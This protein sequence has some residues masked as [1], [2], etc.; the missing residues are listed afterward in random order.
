[1]NSFKKVK[2]YLLD[3]ENNSRSH[4]FILGFLSFLESTILPIPLETV[5]IPY[6]QIHR[7]RIWAAAIVATAG[8]LLGASLF[9][10]AGLQFMDSFGED[11]IKTLSSPET[12]RTLESAVRDHGF[13]FILATGISPIPFQIGMLAAGAVGYS[14]L[15]FMI[16][17]TLARGLRYLGLAWLVLR[18]G[19]RALKIWNENKLKAGLIALAFIVVLYGL[20][21]LIKSL[22]LSS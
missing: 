17:A 9:Y 14:F 6:Y 7:S 3:A 13:V 5:L 18:Y 22:L 21:R 20:G 19:D 15:L 1:M 10:F 4:L 11:L 12:F 8:C 2:R 16:A